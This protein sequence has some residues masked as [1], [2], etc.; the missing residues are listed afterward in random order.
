MKEAYL[1]IGSSRGTV[2]QAEDLALSL[3][4]FGDGAFHQNFALMA[5]GGSHSN[6]RMSA[7][8]EDLTCCR[9]VSRAAGG[10][11]GGSDQ[12]GNGASG[13]SDNSI[14][15]SAGNSGSSGSSSVGASNAASGYNNNGNG[16][17]YDRYG[18]CVCPS[19][20]EPACLYHAAGLK[21]ASLCVLC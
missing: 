3:V 1:L 14:G 19:T 2:V 16:I 10:R 4:S 13:G 5:A 18:G 20:A 8:H 7:S 12:S 21:P 15:N 17:S 11:T 9:G 6:C